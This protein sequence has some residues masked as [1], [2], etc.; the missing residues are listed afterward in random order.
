MT[1]GEDFVRNA[2]CKHAHRLA[3]S[4]SAWCDLNKNC[5][6]LKLHDMCHIAIYNYQKQITF[7]PKQF[8][9]ES[10]GFQNNMKKIFK[11]SQTA[12]NKFLIPAVNVA[13]A[14]SVWPLEQ[15]I[16]IQRSD[17]QRLVY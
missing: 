3:M 16:K 13:A 6:V 12:W 9:Q 2:K 7:T 17:K 14:S 15:I 11:G 5:V 8:Q 1:K 10:N 4:K